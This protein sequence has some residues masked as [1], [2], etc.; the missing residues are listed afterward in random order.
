MYRPGLLR[1]IFRQFVYMFCDFVIGDLPIYRSGLLGI[2]QTLSSK[3][4]REEVRWNCH[5][6]S[7]NGPRRLQDRNISGNVFVSTGNKPQP[8]PSTSPY[9]VTRPHQFIASDFIMLWN[10]YLRYR[11]KENR[12]RMAT[13]VLIY[14]VY[15][16]GNLSTYNS[17]LLGCPC[18]LWISQ[19]FPLYMI[20]ISNAYFYCV[21][22]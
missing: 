18:K 4:Q 20:C 10:I 6:L 2:Y 13:V 22:L 12:F 11:I 7:D 19:Y 3:W 8:Q 16:S 1:C 5:T 15:C 14:C 21:S 17:S 9:C